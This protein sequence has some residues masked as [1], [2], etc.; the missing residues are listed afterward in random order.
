MIN[1]NGVDH[2]LGELE[3][4]KIDVWQ[5]ISLYQGGRD[6][7]ELAEALVRKPQLASNILYIMSEISS[8]RIAPIWRSVVPFLKDPNLNCVFYALDVLH[9]VARQVD[10]E[11]ILL[12][13]NNI[14]FSDYSLSEK[15]EAVRSVASKAR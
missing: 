5:I 4:G 9:S 12:V 7:K 14:H 8:N 11:E 15:I 3:H 13:L 1:E 6:V 2:L 10:E